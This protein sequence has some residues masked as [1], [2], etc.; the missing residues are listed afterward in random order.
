MQ[1]DLSAG[2]LPLDR[3]QLMA[4]LN[5]TPDSFSDGGKY[6]SEQ[7]WLD[8]VERLVKDGADILDIGGESTRPGAEPI[9]AAT[10]R[11]R[12]V[13]VVEAVVKYFPK[14]LVSVDTSKASVAKAALDVGAAI[15][16]DVSSLRDPA[17][18]SVVAD[19]DAGLIVMHMRGTPE[20]MQSGPIDY[21][22]VSSEV[23]VY[24]AAAIARAETCGVPKRRMMVDPGIGFGKQLE[25]NLT[26]TRDLG[27]L[28]ALGCPVVYGPS[29]KRFLGDITGR[30]VTDRDRA[31]A[32]A[33]VAAVLN[34][35]QILRVHN[36]AAVR[37]AV[38]IA[39]ALSSPASVSPGASQD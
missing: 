35:A 23:A 33:C 29:R 19:A 4:V 32:A 25:H 3:P 34:G 16:N 10:E 27:R 24:L 39:A 5:V 8:Q 13:P 17:M 1:L 7:Q 37:D 9:D 31:T 28:A 2:P 22:D 18:G 20:T 12:V 11:E 30:P 38:R 6:F 36:V 26:L 21:M 14:M 15:I